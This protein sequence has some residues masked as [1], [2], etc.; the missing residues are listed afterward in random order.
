MEEE[1]EEDA[2]APGSKYSRAN[3]N[4]DDEPRWGTI[5]CLLFVTGVGIAGLALAIAA[6]VR[7]NSHDH[8]VAYGEASLMTSPG[9]LEFDEN[10]TCMPVSGFKIDHEKGMV[11]GDSYIMVNTP[12]IYWYHLS[13]KVHFS[14]HF[15]RWTPW[16]LFLGVDGVKKLGEGSAHDIAWFASDNETFWDWPISPYAP[17][18]M[19]LTNM[20]DMAA[21]QKFNMIIGFPE[22]CRFCGLIEQSTHGPGNVTLVD[23]RMSI[24]MIDE[25]SPGSKAAAATLLLLASLV[26]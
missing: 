21:G 13:A 26:V 6:L 23:A 1:E 2:M 16:Q 5:I 22:F 4:N 25:T 8:P 20:V 17:A 19:D 12:G 24:R 10:T 18:D 14:E 7:V 3:G 11:V 9:F 15:Y